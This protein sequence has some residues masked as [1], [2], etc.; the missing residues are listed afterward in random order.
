VFAIEAVLA[1]ER[2]RSQYRSSVRYREAVFG[3]ERLC[4]L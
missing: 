4:S 2:L 3:I 1:I